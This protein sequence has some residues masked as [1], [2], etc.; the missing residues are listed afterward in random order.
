MCDFQPSG[1][2]FP[3]RSQTE[4]PEPK[5]ST[6]NWK[7]FIVFVVAPFTP[8][9][10]SVQRASNNA[11]LSLQAAPAPI[12]MFPAGNESNRS[13]APCLTC[14]HFVLLL[15]LLRCQFSSGEP[16]RYSP[17]PRLALP[18]PAPSPRPSHRP[19][20]MNDASVPTGSALTIYESGQPFASGCGV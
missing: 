9:P 2:I 20:A 15:P 6:T 11:H 18:R 7:I 14:L 3:V 16:A 8:T 5:R 19:V 1:C 12:F 13:D 10:S 17:S 4:P